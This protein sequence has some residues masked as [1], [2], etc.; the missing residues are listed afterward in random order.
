MILCTGGLKKRIV[1]FVKSKNI[2]SLQ[3][4]SELKQIL[5]S[6]SHN[7]LWVWEFFIRASPLT[8]E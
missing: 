1:S 5:C 6:E 8:S 2:L 7:W 3:T 4:C